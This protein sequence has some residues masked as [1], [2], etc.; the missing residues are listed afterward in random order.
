MK[1]QF[2]GYFPLPKERIK[3][4]W[5]KAIFV[6]DANILLGLYRYSD[7]TRKEFFSTL[8]TIKDRCWLPH[9]AVKEYFD[10][11]LNVIGKQ[12]DS[13]AEM[14]KAIDDIEQKFKMAHQHPFL[15][16]GSLKQ[17]CANF[18]VVRKELGKS[19]KFHTDRVSNDDVLNQIE[20]IFSGKIGLPY[21]DVELVEILKEGE[22]RYKKSIPP[23]FRDAKKDDAF[24]ATRKFGDLILWKQILRKASV[25]K[26][27]IVFVCDDRKDDWWLQFKGKTLGARPELVK[28]FRCLAGTDLHMYSS[29]RFLEFAGEHFNR[30]VSEIAVSEMRDFKRFDEERNR[31]FEDARRQ[32]INEA[33]SLN[34][35]RSNEAELMRMPELASLEDRLSSL[36]SIHN[37]FSDMLRSKN[38]RTIS[39]SDIIRLQDYSNSIKELEGK[40]AYLRSE[41]LE[42]SQIP[43][44]RKLPIFV[45]KN[46]SSKASMRNAEE[47]FEEFLK[48]YPLEDEDS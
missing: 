11:R 37:Y 22:D 13:Y 44:Q 48:S 28:E 5:D 24:D 45:N 3:R 4:L 35:V 33:L 21:S 25:D 8:A 42:S 16:A 29:D 20:A 30:A 10:N 47:D 9:Q 39:E 14:M 2:P 36:R 32:G 17:L 23:G 26:V 31:S 18:E 19:K 43:S 12:E 1:D 38:P 41:V 27:G 46:K 40:I 7:A 34:S 6:F 15:S